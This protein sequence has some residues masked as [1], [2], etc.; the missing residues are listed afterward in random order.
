[1]SEQGGV[2]R[3]PAQLPKRGHH[4][5]RLQ[6]LRAIR[7]RHQR[8]GRLQ[9]RG[10]L[11]P[12]AR[13]SAAHFDLGRGPGA[14]QSSAAHLFWAVPVLPLVCAGQQ[15][16]IPGAGGGI[17]YLPASGFRSPGLVQLRGPGRG[18]VLLRHRGRAPGNY[19][20]K[21]DL[22]G[23]R[24]GERELCSGGGPLQG[25]G[26]HGRLYCSQ[27]RVLPP[28]AVRLLQQLVPILAQPGL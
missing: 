25:G 14:R 23:F 28:G 22:V 19:Y 27:I 6:L 17:H 13:L 1:M 20:R 24:C 12:P 7:D 4:H 15:D 5:Q 10:D 26:L 9:R 2:L 11:G 16:H 18:A 8:F 21:L 3:E